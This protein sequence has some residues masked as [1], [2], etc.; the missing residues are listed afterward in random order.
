MFAKH[1]VTLAVMAIFAVMIVI[2]SCSEDVTDPYDIELGGT[3]EVA[4]ISAAEGAAIAIDG[5]PTGSDEAWSKAEEFR[6]VVQD[7]LGNMAV[8]GMRAL[9]DSTYF[10]LNVRWRDPTRDVRP[11]HWVFNDSNGGHIPFVGGQD[12]FVAM[13]DDG[14]N[15]DVKADCW[16]MCHLRGDGP[17]SIM[18]NDGPGMVDAW[19]WESGQTDPVRTLADLHYPPGDTFAFDQMADR[20]VPIWAENILADDIRWMH[21]DSLY[22]EGD[23]LFRADY[24]TW[25]AIFY[26]AE[27]GFIKWPYGAVIPGYLL[28]DSVVYYADESCWE[29]EAKGFYEETEGFWEVEFKRELDTGFADD[30]PFVL[31]GKI[32]CT[33]AVTNSP[34]YNSPDPH[35]GSEP[36][37]IQL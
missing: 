12:F 3:M 34:N 18:R 23:F 29:I 2:L 15:G 19:I 1:Y 24:V 22:Y 31:G 30:I 36:F 4:H 11:D 21:K 37:E 35:F 33:I 28:A 17:Y 27:G 32:D 13:F 7:T 26:D 9:T 10:Y 5:N 8:V 14:N 6:I 25:R 16:Q 20:P